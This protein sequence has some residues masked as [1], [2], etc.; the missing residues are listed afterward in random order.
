[1]S[2]DNEFAK[3]VQRIQAA[4]GA[5]GHTAGQRQRKAGLG[6]SP[7]FRFGIIAVAL[8]A[9]AVGGLAFSSMADVGAKIGT[10]V[11]PEELMANAGGNAEAAEAAAQ[12]EGDPVAYLPP[13]PDGW[14]RVTAVD[15][16]TTDVLATLRAQWPDPGTGEGVL[17]LEDNVGFAQLTHYLEVRRTPDMEQRVLAKKSTYALYLHPNGQFLNVGLAFLSERRALGAATDQ[18]S[19]VRALSTEVEKDR[20]SD[21]VLEVLTLAGFDAVNRTKAAGESLVTRPIAGNLSGLTGFRISAALTHRAVIEIQGI[22]APSVAEALV[23]SVDIDAL[24][25]RLQ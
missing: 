6:E 11:Y 21:E 18:Q 7:G 5:D 12:A 2:D 9:V 16:A 3:R 13:A 4:R 25:A 8:G 23:A 19:W 10:A 15:A 20:Q 1:M 17:A 22:A 24:K 14:F